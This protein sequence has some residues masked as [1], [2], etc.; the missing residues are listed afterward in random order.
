[1]MRNT[2]YNGTIMHPKIERYITLLKQYNESVNIF[3]RTGYDHLPFHVQDSIYIA[4]LIQSLMEKRIIK[5][6]PSVIDMGSGGGFP[7]V[8]TAILLPEIPV[9][10]IESKLKKAN[11]LSLVQ[12]EIDLQNYKVINDD[13]HSV[14]KKHQAP[15]YT[16]KA[17]KKYPEVI[18][19][20]EEFAP[21]GSQCIIPISQGQVAEIQASPFNPKIQ[22]YHPNT[23]D[24][25]YCYA[26]I[27]TQKPRH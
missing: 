5:L 16:A 18:T 9:T 26:I 4:A 15:V 21:R 17:F 20:I 27:G 6:P 14:L 3:S 2:L 25:Q 10:A 24:P 19:L 11:F 13:V 12:K 22:L 7:S 23:D 8:I 1:M